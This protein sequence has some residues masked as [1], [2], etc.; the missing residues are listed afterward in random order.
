VPHIG[1]FLAVLRVGDISP[2]WQLVAALAVFT[3]ALAI[4]LTGNRAI[5]AA[6]FPDSSG[7]QYQID[8]RQDVFDTF[9]VMLNATC[10]QQH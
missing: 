10:M 8:A 5:A 4:T 7:G 3:S 2:T 6:W 9:G 1:N